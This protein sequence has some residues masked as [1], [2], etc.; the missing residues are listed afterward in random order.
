MAIAAKNPRTLI[1]RGT[2]VAA[3]TQLTGCTMT[4]VGGAGT[5]VNLAK[6]GNGLGAGDALLVEALN[7]EE[8]NGIFPV[9]ADID[10]DNVR[11]VIAQDPGAD[12][13]A[14]IGKATKGVLSS[15]FD[16]S[17]AL[18]GLIV[19]GVQNG[20]TGP[21]LG[22]QVWLG[23]GSSADAYDFLWQQ[24]LVASVSAGAFTPFTYRVPPAALRAAVWIG[25]N[26][27]QAVDAYAIGHELSSIG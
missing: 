6:T 27:A 26:T 24:L 21:T 19:G 13:A 8:Y 12:P 25:G 23:F 4:R 20:S 10:A 11:Y 5:T 15:V 1:A 2:P 22:A 14:A 18:G 3:F 7:L 17:T 16:L 9:S